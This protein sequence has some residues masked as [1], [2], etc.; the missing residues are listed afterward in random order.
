MQIYYIG[1][2][3]V[4]K[5][6]EV[7]RLHAQEVTQRGIASSTGHSRN[8][9]REVLK[10]AKEKEV[11]WPLENNVTDLDLQII[12]YPEKQT[13]SDHRQKPD[14]EYIHK[15]LAKS[16]VTLSLLWDEYTLQCRQNNEIPYSYRQFCRFYNEYARKAKATMRIKRKPG[17][18]MEV[19][20]AGQTMC[21]TNNLTGEEIPVYIFVAALPCSQYAYVEGF[22][23][24]NLE[25]WI[26]AHIHAF[27][28]YGGVTR[29]LVPDNL[30]TGVT[31]ASRTDPIIN[32]SYQEMAEHYQTTI[33]P[34]RIRSPKDKAS[35]EGNVGHISTWIIA[36]LRNEKFFSL[37]ELNKAIQEKLAIV[38]TKPF[39][40]K[41]GNRQE[42][43]LK[44]E[45][46]ALASLPHS[47]YEIA[48]WAKAVVQP[49]YH[50]KVDNNH[51]SVPYDYIK[52]TV[53]VRVTRNIIETFYK[54]IRISSHKRSKNIGG[55]F[56]T[57]PDHMP[58]D[59][60]KYAQFNKE[61]I[62]NWGVTVGPSTLLTI[63]RI[64][65]SYPT[66]KQGL[67]STYGLM[68]LADKYSIERIEKACERVLSYTPRPKLK[69]I[70][71]I[72]KT[73]HDKLPLENTKTQSDTQ[74]N[75]NTYGFTRGANYYGGK[76][77][78]N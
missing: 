14:G 11:Y 76:N 62:L 37:L 58:Q 31:K 70:Q 36:S 77:N 64:I 57:T 42:A 66:E 38:N 19:D 6:R 69:S 40:K 46:F 26:T 51:Y 34:A 56:I 63:E 20:W 29:V 74:K 15:E 21:L 24:M 7:L 33:I 54:N 68:K 50:I 1:G 44:E 27:E 17:E 55:E 10:R 28:F 60:R 13:P 5:Y 47:P 72:L 65:E 35:V 23:S 75:N 3:F 78:D 32:Q 53:D 22:L 43:F 52:C 71:T 48:S 59:H 45:K 41:E 4:I 18:Q 73:G 16:G 67:K 61:F 25:S 8:T 2:F 49:D 39:Q 12:L 30:K 9:I